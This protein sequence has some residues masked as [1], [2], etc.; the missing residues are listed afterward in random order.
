[1]ALV[2]RAQHNLSW[3]LL[4]GTAF[5]PP[6]YNEAYSINNPVLRGNPQ[7]RSETSRT[8][9][10]GLNWQI[11]SAWQLN[12]NLYQFRMQDVILAQPIP[13]PGIGNTFQ[14]SGRFHA[15]GLELE[16]AWDN[17]QDWRINANYSRQHTIEVS[18]G[19][20]AGYLPQHRFYLRGEWRPTADWQFGLQGNA[21]LK[22]ARSP[23][24]T[25]PPI[26]DYHTFD[27]SARH[28]FADKRWQLALAIT[29][30]SNADARE[31][32]PAPGLIP[33]DIPLPGRSF[34]LEIS[35]RF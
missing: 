11:N 31:P 8:L 5:R 35:T 16:A 26:A 3:K 30:L 29:N 20:D 32:S 13:A 23:G 17:H 2:W 9:E 18:S 6:S 1:M 10:T 28:M 7:L 4:Y 15:R 34:S 14:N 22:R 12:A 33:Y 24:D 21:V 19:K 27:L 25:R